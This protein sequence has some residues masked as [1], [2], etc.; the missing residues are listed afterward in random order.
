VNGRWASA[1]AGK[2]DEFKNFIYFFHGEVALVVTKEQSGLIGNFG[3]LIQTISITWNT[4]SG[5]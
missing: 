1:Q 4:L 5:N 2:M 3:K